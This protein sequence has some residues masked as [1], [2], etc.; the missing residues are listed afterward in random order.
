MRPQNL[1]NRCLSTAL[2]AIAVTWAAPAAAQEQTDGVIIVARD[3]PD[4]YAFLPHA[5]SAL[6]VKTAPF[7]DIWGG[8]FPGQAMTDAQT[9]QVSSDAAPP[10]WQGTSANN[11]DIRRLSTLDAARSDVG[12][13]SAQASGVG[14]IVS[15]T[16][17][18]GM[19]S[20]QSG[21]SQL[22]TAMGQNQ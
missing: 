11:L 20:L 12:S 17:N 5:G 2:L 19:Q 15:S 3:V 4:G 10:D 21:L 18:S 22:Q 1:P 16:V 13:S 14:G 8:I 7:A 6:T 9:D